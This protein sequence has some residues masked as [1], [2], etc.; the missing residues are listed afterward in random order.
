VKFWAQVICAVFLA[1]SS[2]RDLASSRHGSE[3]LACIIVDAA[4]LAV[5]NT[6]GLFSELLP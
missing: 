2:I 5:L 6:A 3:V 1:A 4:T